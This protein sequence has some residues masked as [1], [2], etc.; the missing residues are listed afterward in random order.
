MSSLPPPP[1]MPPPPPPPPGG[2]APPPVGPPVSG[3]EHCYRHPDREAGRRC[4]RCGRVACTDCLVQASVGSHCV[5]CV[6]ATR[7]PAA[8]RIQR[9]NATSGFLV[10]KAI[11]AINVAVFIYMIVRDND[12]IGGRQVSSASS[13]LGLHR[14]FLQEGEWYRLVT[15][16]FIHFGLI[17]LA[18][19]M[20]ALWNLGQMLEPASGRLRFA[21]MYFA[22][23][24]AGSAGVVIQN[25]GGITGGASGAVFGLFGA[26]AIALRQRGINPL[27]TSIGTVLILN[28]V[29]T[30]AIPGISIGGHLGGLVGGA[31]CGVAV[32]S[33]PWKRLPTWIGYGGPIAVAVVSVAISAAL[34]A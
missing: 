18:F 29:L 17:H 33:P 13:E 30:F 4:T 15:A 19:N 27:Q 25:G 2:G 26:A 28:L 6:K 22:A 16:G 7:P 21:L 20:F 11:I 8:V 23:L 1:P 5:E 24:L 14:F 9:W 31:L 10:T 3:V 12:A 32:F 34:A